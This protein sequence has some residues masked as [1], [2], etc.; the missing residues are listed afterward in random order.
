MNPDQEQLDVA[1]LEVQQDLER[2]IGNGP[3]LGIAAL[4]PDRRGPESLRSLANGPDHVMLDPAPCARSFRAL[5]THGLGLPMPVARRTSHRSSPTDS[6]A[7]IRAS[8]RFRHN[9][10]DPSRAIPPGCSAK[11][12]RYGRRFVRT[13]AGCANPRQPALLRRDHEEIESSQTLVTGP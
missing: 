11:S 7:P 1:D 10:T 3:E 8:A 5:G 6:A 2:R 13:P 4:Q 9:P 12:N